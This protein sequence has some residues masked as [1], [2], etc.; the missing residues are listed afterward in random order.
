MTSSVVDLSQH[1][2][3]CFDRSVLHSQ[4]ILGNLQSI[5]AAGMDTLHRLASGHG[6]ATVLRSALLGMAASV[7]H[8]L[9]CWAYILHLIWHNDIQYLILC[10]SQ[11]AVIPCIAFLVLTRFW[12]F[13]PNDERKAEDRWM[14]RGMP[15]RDIISSYA[16]C[17][18]MNA[19]YRFTWYCGFN[20]L[21]W[22]TLGHFQFVGVLP[23]H[24]CMCAMPC[25]MTVHSLLISTARPL[26]P[27][28]G[29]GKVGFAPNADVL[30]A[31]MPW[32]LM[33]RFLQLADMPQAKSKFFWLM[34]ASYW[35]ML[36]DF[37]KT[38]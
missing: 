5:A 15:D 7:L 19:F 2:T 32:H 25:S 35:L 8:R 31:L 38:L 21:S 10:A 1:S 14:R 37:L 29:A 18:V 11:S 3:N 12:T 16:A 26:H 28:D 6:W 33:F 13:S 4:V 34:V 20:V 22:R 17:A 9:R 24:D 36:L 27:G 30:A 23:C